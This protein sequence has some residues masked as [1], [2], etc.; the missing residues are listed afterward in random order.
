MSIQILSSKVQANLAKA[1]VV[2]VCDQV[3]GVKLAV[4]PRVSPHADSFVYDWEDFDPEYAN[5]GNTEVEGLLKKFHASLTLID[6]DGSKAEVLDASEVED[7]AAEVEVTRV[8]L[9]G[10]GESHFIVD[11]KDANFT[12]HW[13]TAMAALTIA[14]H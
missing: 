14:Y 8:P 5:Q 2:K 12:L 13:N 6:W 9:S 7:L 11:H 3:F 4:C 10:I 1:D